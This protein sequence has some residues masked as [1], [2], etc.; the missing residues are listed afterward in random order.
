MNNNKGLAL[1]NCQELISRTSNIFSVIW[2]DNTCSTVAESS[3]NASVFIPTSDSSEPLNFSTIICDESDVIKRNQLIAEHNQNVLKLPIYPVCDRNNEQIF[4]QEEIVFQFGAAPCSFFTNVTPLVEQKNIA[5]HVQQR[6][7]LVLAGTR[8]GMWD[9]NPQTNEVYFDERWADMLGVKLTDLHQVLSDWQDRVH[10]DDIA[11]CFEDIT[12]HMEGKTE[13]YENLHR[14]KHADGEWRY[15]LDRGKV[16]E[17]NNE[18]QPIRFTGTHTDVTELKL[19]ELKAKE[20]LETRSRFFANMSHELRTPLHG[21][22]N[23]AEI[24]LTETSSNEKNKAL[25]SILDAATSLSSIV[26]DILDFAKIEAGKLELEE[27]EIELQKLLHTTVQ[28]LQAAAEKKGIYLTYKLDDGV[29]PILKGDPVRLSQV[30]TNLCA[31]AIKFT[32]SGGVTIEIKKLDDTGAKQTLQFNVIDTGIGIN[33]KSQIS[34]F[35]EFHQADNST[36]RKYGGTGLGLSICL[37]L[38]E[39]MGGKLTLESE[40][41]VGSTFTYTQEFPVENVSKVQYK[42]EQIV[43]LEGSSLL[44]VEDNLVNQT[45]VKKMLE[46]HNAVVNVVGDGQQC[47]QF[48]ADTPVDLIF[49]DIQMPVMDGIQATK[50]IIADPNLRDIPIIAMTANT[51]KE[52]IERYLKLGMSGY[53]TKPFNRSKLNSL[54]NIYNPKTLNLNRFATKIGDPNIDAE[55]KLQLSCQQLKQLIPNA[56]RVSLWL[57][58]SNHTEINC[59][60]CLDH[61]DQI[62]SGIVL[63]AQ[64]FPEYFKFIVKNQVLDASNA[65]Q[66]PVTECFN[67]SYFKP[68][69][70]HSLLD[71]IFLHDDKPLGVICCET[72]ANQVKWQNEDKIALV[73]VADITT[74]F[75][76]DFITD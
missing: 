63:G 43:D 60:A 67:E 21:I 22:L 24:A 38:S 15:I 51:M 50:A 61:E 58:N 27:L 23:L 44:V 18:G 71:F 28:P 19:A 13:F 1:Q 39:M 37:K 25:N 31:N 20:V 57:F 68:L 69:N 5:T 75:L 3:E 11:A 10:P 64:D 46:G 41:G 35:E 62:S 14:M 7:E 12:A 48:L 30:L 53:I 47:L 40:E 56:N 65:R 66:H 59:I 70:I 49:M 45:V 74:L 8:L 76:A 32:N 42:T 52:D 73:K 72:V 16:V 4:L 29:A 55:E 6:L 26:N 17:R 34:L 33:K 9:W 36:S 2:S 54:L